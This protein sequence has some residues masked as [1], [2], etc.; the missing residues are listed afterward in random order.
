[1][2]STATALDITVGTNV[3]GSYGKLLSTW[4]NTATVPATLGASTTYT[5]GT[6]AGQANFYAEATASISGGSSID[7]YGGLSDAFGQTGNLT[8][9][10]ELIVVNTSTT[11]GQNLVLT[12]NFITAALG[13]VT[14]I[15]VQ[16]GGCV[17]FSSPTDGYTVTTSTQDTI[18]LTPSSGTLIYKLAVVGTM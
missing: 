9:V 8:V 1:M 11:A 7:L 13:T 18:T 2:A 17:R 4:F 3:T 14:N 16:P 6:S 15:A 12:G 5:Y 10:R